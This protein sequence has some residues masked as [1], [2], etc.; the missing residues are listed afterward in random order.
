MILCVFFLGNGHTE[1]EVIVVGVEMD[2]TMD[3]AELFVCMLL[4]IPSRKITACS[5]AKFLCSI[6]FNL[7]AWVK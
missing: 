5:F 6:V 7:A 4:G 2:H 3:D 1:C